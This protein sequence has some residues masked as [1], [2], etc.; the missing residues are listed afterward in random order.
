MEKKLKKRKLRT[1]L[2]LVKVIAE[3][4]II[5]SG[6]FEIKFEKDIYSRIDISIITS[7]SR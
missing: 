3:E 7:C 2:E 4:N 5:G 1:I 6:K